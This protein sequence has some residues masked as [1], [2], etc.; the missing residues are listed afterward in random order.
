[1]RTFG[2]W[3]GRLVHDSGNGLVRP[4]GTMPSGSDFDLAITVKSDDPA[5]VG[6]CLDYLKAELAREAAER[7]EARRLEVEARIELNAAGIEAARRREAEATKRRE[8]EA[9]VAADEA[10]RREAAIAAAT[11][12]L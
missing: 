7:E 2:F 12:R 9:I 11:A 4:Q 8:A 3:Q 10:R 6:S 5:T 1:M